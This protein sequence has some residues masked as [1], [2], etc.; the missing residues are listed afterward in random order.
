MK[1]ANTKETSNRE[2]ERERI[3][4]INVGSKRVEFKLRTMCQKETSSSK[5]VIRKGPA[6]FQSLF[7]K[8]LKRERERQQKLD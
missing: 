2:R 7:A 8:V 1:R 6:L 5:G 3:M 4:D